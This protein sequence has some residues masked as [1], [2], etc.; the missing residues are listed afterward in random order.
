MINTINSAIIKF[1]NIIKVYKYKNNFIK[2]KKRMESEK[3]II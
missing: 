1:Y 2:L 3:K